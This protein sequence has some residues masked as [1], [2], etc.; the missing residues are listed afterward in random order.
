MEQ[1]VKKRLAEVITWLQGEFAAIR[2]GQA[3]PALLDGIKVE[4]YGSYLPLNQV[5]SVGTEDARTLR[6]SP[7]DVSQIAGIER[8]IQEANLGVSVATDS[9]GIRVIFPELTVERRAQLQKLAKSKQEDARIRVRSVRDDFMKDIEKRL[10]EGEISE[11]DKF[12]QKETVQKAVDETNT[13][14]E[15]LFNKKEKELQN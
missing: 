6:I 13:S 14:L 11:D 5:G 2:T 10:K 15:S 9:A 12:S 4:S 7:W 1:D 8:A 3:S